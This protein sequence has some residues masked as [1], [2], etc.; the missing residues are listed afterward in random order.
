MGVVIQEMVKADQAG[1]LFTRD[2]VTGDCATMVI[3]SN[4]GVGE[5]SSKAVT[6]TQSNYVRS[7]FG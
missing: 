4:Y 3:N 5:V 6:P 7:C 2:P 1:V